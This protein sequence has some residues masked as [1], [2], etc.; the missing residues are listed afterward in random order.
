MKQY[1]NFTVSKKDDVLEFRMIVMDRRD[2]FQ[3]F[4]SEL[5]ERNRELWITPPV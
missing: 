4:P 3:L 5:Q 2:I 1:N